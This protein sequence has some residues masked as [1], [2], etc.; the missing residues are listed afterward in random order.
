MS[1]GLDLGSTGVRCLSRSVRTLRGRR[2]PACYVTLPGGQAEK[3]LLQRALI[4]YSACDGSFV[5][6]GEN[7][8]ELSRALKI[9]CIPVF[10]EGRLPQQ[11]PVG[12]QVAATLIESVLPSKAPTGTAILVVAGEG[13]AGS[14]GTVDLAP[15]A[16][17]VLALRGIRSLPL[18]AGT[19]AVLGGLGDRE[20]TG[21]GLS[22]GAH[23]TC[24]S[25][26]VHGQPVAEFTIGRGCAG[27]DEVMAKSRGRYFFD[28]EGNR[29][30]DVRAIAQW[31]ETSS[32]DLASPEG[33]DQDLLRS[34]VREWLLKAFSDFASK[35]EALKI[36]RYVRSVSTMAI[37]GGPSRMAGFDV[38]VADALRRAQLPLSMTEIRTGEASDYTIAR[39]A[40]IA[41]ELEEKVK[42]PKAA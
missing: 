18:H 13:L 12:R 26:C 31:R 15:F 28:G 3:L 32:V 19:A 38:L 9:P 34:L 5:I 20:F 21:V 37:T 22:V 6:F 10:P 40:L 42:A 23:A 7:A 41:A 25:V 1:L 36:G 27:V 30:L 8:I 33:D 29:Y 2:A 11:D 35:L 4:P 24:L 14:Q 16:D 17:R 39:G